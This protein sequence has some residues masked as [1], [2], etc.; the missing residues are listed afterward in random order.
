MLSRC[1][2]GRVM[3]NSTD[4]EKDQFVFFWHGPFSNWHLCTFEVDGTWF[5]CVEQYMMARKAIMFEDTEIY[6]RI[7]S[8]D[9][10]SEQK[11][12]GRRV[13]GFNPLRWDAAAKNIVFRGA[14]AKFSQNESLKKALLETGEKILVEASPYDKIWG[15]G[16]S[17]DDP[18]ATDPD[19]WEGTNWLGEVLMQVRQEILDSDE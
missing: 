19:Q 13:K 11:R 6:D 3:K 16:L 7:M 5:N 15:I 10:P 12:L 9:A 18:R 4:V 8:T 14:C 2:N 1:V 17:A